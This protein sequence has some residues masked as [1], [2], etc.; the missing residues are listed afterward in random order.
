[1]GV[2]TFFA[3][4]VEVYG[5]EKVVHCLNAASGRRTL[6]MFVVVVLSVSETVEH[7]DTCG[8]SIKTRPWFMGTTRAC[9]IRCYTRLESRYLHFPIICRGTCSL[10]ESPIM[11]HRDSS[12]IKILY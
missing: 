5:F 7:I 4:G 11:S 8:L 10:A 12:I 6:H 3:G 1:V 9:A 2:R